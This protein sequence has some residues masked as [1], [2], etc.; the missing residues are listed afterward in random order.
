MTHNYCSRCNLLFKRL[1]YCKY[2]KNDDD[3]FFLCAECVFEC[4]KIFK[5]TF[6]LKSGKF[7]SIGLSNLGKKEVFFLVSI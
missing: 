2:E 3:Y 7:V 6:K 4:R 5:K 1:F